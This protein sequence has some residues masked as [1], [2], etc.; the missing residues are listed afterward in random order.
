MRPDSATRALSWAFGRLKPGHRTLLTA[1]GAGLTWGATT[2][3][4]PGLFP[5]PPTQRSRT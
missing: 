2:L 4:W 1:F 3:T 5:Q